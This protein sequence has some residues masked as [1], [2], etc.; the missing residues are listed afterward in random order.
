MDYDESYYNATEGV[1]SAIQDMDHE[2][3]PSHFQIKEGQVEEREASPWVALDNEVDFMPKDVTEDTYRK[4][5]TLVQDSVVH[6]MDNDEQMDASSQ[7]HLQLVD[8]LLEERE[9][10]LEIISSEELDMG[11]MVERE[12]S[13]QVSL[14]EEVDFAKKCD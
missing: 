2:V 5:A 6:N 9:A 7:T 3:H 13:A 10:F 8:G 14:D 1:I 4:E 12:T 11:I